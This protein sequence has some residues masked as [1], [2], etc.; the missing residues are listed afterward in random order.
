MTLP[1]P[2]AASLA[3]HAVLLGPPHHRVVRYGPEMRVL[4]VGGG[5][6]GLTLAALLEQRGF[7]PVVVE[8]AAGYAG[9]G[10]AIG[11]WPA[12]SRILK[13][14]KLFTKLGDA[15]VE[16]ARYII[17]NERGDTLH[18]FSFEPVTKR[19]GPMVEIGRRNLIDLLRSRVDERRV[20]FGVAIRRIT[21]TPDGVIAEF[22]DGTADVFD[23][24][25]GCDGMRS[26][27]RQLAFG[28][29]Q[30]DYSGV[31]GW[32][33]WLPPDFVPPP[34]IIEYWGSGKFVGMYP[35]R[36][37]FCAVVGMH[38]PLAIPDPP[39][40]RLQR[41]RTSFAGFGGIVPWVLS[42]LPEPERMLRIEFSDVRTDEW[43]RG[44][45]VLI[46]DAAHAMLPT[47]G[48]GASMAME[49]AAVLAEELCRTDSKFLTASLQQ[50]ASRRRARV[51][52]V[53]AR[54]RRIARV[55]FAGN[56]LVARIRDEA[57]RI[58][59]DEPLLDTVDQ[60]MAE[61]I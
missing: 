41:L 46:G 49:S 61:R 30:V 54:S 47:T 34:E 55:L 50:Y 32:A 23:V 56:G 16:C 11:L 26:S 57:I 53:Q 15:G 33:F 27:V 19:Y 36:R 51:A 4:I 43:T 52:R 20:R 39:E 35:A 58:M 29:V 13:G 14:L 1:S 42:E 37:Q 8:K 9:E 5:V 12:G 45:V 38:S 2:S 22:D 3:N 24:I 18:S 60:V 17:A 28:E 10:Y 44:R 59:V 21:E 31:A 40:T 7:A 6:A 48:M 25:V